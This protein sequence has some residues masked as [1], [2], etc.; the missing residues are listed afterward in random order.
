VLFREVLPNPLPLIVAQA[1][2][3]R[4]YRDGISCR[5]LF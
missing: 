5:Q 2:H 4:A 1:K 3:A